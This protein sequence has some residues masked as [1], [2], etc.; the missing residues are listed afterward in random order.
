[1]LAVLVGRVMRHGEKKP[2]VIYV[3]LS[4]LIIHVVD[5]AIS[6]NVKL[7]PYEIRILTN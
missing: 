3:S 1:M 7:W 2:H 5:F 4:S 6:D